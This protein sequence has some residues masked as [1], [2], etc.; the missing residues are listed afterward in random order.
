[1]RYANGGDNEE[2]N[3]GPGQVVEPPLR[4][5]R[6][7]WPWVFALVVLVMCGGGFAAIA[8]NMG[9][10]SDSVVITPQDTVSTK[11]TPKRSASPD[12]IQEGTWIVGTDVK[13][14]KYKTLG[15]ADSQIPMCYWDVRTGSETGEIIA[16]G[17]KDK[18]NAQGLVTLKKGQYF[19]TS[20]CSDWMLQTTDEAQNLTWG[21]ASVPLF[22]RKVYVVVGSGLSGWPVASASNWID[23]YTGSDWV[24]SKTCP[25]SAYRCVRVVKDNGL[26]A[27]VLAAT[28]GYNTSRVTIRVDVAY[29]NSRGYTSQ[30]RRKNIIAHE[31]GHAGF[32]KN[33]SS[34]CGN[35][36]YA[37][38]RCIGWS[39]TSS[40][41]KI[42]AAH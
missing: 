30:N 9:D 3:I 17:V 2:W 20:G 18:A 6:R 7:V 28:Y 32:I 35:L 40:Q 23:R 42:L 10:S 11:A 4:K 38:T 14:G 16:Q 24:V 1:M 5:K 41:K 36:M 33:H 12:M 25:S 13:P 31:F 22:K 29:A 37:S 26:K 15:A 34:A 27:P 21:T 8:S 19:T 39:L